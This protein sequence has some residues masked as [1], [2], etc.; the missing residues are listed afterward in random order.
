MITLT[1]ISKTFDGGGTFVVNNLSLH[2]HRGEL[3][4]ILGESGSGKT[5]TLR[6]IN[7]LVEPTEGSIHVNGRNT[8]QTDRVE[9]RRSI[10]YVFQGIGLFPHM[11]VEENIAVVPRLLRWDEKQISTRVTELMT[12]MGL[13]VGAMRN[14]RP[15]ELSGGQQQRVGVA[16]ALAAKPGVLL[17]DE[18]FGALDPLT[19]DSLQ[20]ELKRIQQIQ[21][22]SI[23]LVTHDMTEALLLGDRIAILHQGTLRAIGTPHDLLTNAD[24]PYVVSLMETPKRQADRVEMIARGVRSNE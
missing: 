12:L 24:D 22:I 13:D 23:I 16:R 6:M 5:T 1:S 2:V 4:V 19:R 18:P 7:R 10:G 20:T 21:N 11:T 3:L 8:A 9:L 15:D 14:R 17:M